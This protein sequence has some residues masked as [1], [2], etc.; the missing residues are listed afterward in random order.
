MTGIED[1]QQFGREV[2]RRGGH[3]KA[4]RAAFQIFEPGQS[5]CH[6][7]DLLQDL[8]R[9]LAHFASGFGQKQLFAHVLEQRLADL[10]FQLL[11]LHGNGGLGEVQLLGRAGEAQVLSDRD[12]GL[13]LF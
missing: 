4:Q 6:V 7:I 9:V 12:K 13:Q 8:T 1:R 5:G 2:V 11:Q 3:R 10:R